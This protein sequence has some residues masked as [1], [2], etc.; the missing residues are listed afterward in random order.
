VG[1]TDRIGTDEYN[2]KLSENRANAVKEYLDS[3]VKLDS[4]IVEIKW[5]GKN[6]LII[7]CLDT[8]SRTELIQCLA[9]NRRV[10]V[11]VD[12]YDQRKISFIR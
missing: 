12:Y 10:E 9:P 5:L 8:M 4:S 3:Q 1:Y 7:K 6:N 11:E 2:Y